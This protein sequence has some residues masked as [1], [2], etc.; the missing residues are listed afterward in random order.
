MIGVLE[1]LFFL[2]VF[3]L[4]HS[5]LLF[6]FALKMLARNKKNN[7]ITFDVNA[8][9]LPRVSAIISIY[10]EEKVIEEKLL[11]LIHSDYPKDKLEIFVG[12]DCSTDRSNEIV[13]K[14]AATYDFLHFF[15]YK[16]RSGKPGVLNK[17]SQVIFSRFPKSEN[18]ILL[19]TDA[20]V[21]LEK[22]TLFELVKHFKNKDIAIVDANMVNVGM[23]STGIS[24]S[25]NQYIKSEVML[26]HNESLV[27]QKMLGPFGGCYTLRSSYFNEIPK[28]YLVDDFFIAMK[29]LAQ[30]G[31]VINEL[32][33]VCYESVSHDIME[34]YKRKSRI[35]AGNFQN[36]NH[37]KTVLWPPNTTL[38]FRFFSHKILRWIGPFLMIVSFLSSGIL[39]LIHFNRT[40]FFQVVF[41]SQFILF[42][43]LPIL[44][45]LLKKVNVNNL[46]LKNISYF[47]FMNLALLEGFFNYL[48]GIKKNTWEPPKRQ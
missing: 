6:P 47:L 22:K 28:N 36:L 20:N 29:V 1:I 7:P 15:E 34:E 21:I 40:V 11:S 2:S 19:L 44:N 42:I 32:A 8:Q 31:L 37:F 48:K 14:M 4:I 23:K 24:K 35:S 43:G 18:H 46:L 10:N 26:K 45:F 38:A 16:E 13:S 41:L 9:D 33:A 30:G 5:Y 17:L 3:G 27:K 12:S 39:S 25:E